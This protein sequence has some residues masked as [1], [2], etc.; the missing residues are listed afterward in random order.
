M[1]ECRIGPWADPER[2]A[3]LFVLISS[4]LSLH[5]LLVMFLDHVRI[6]AIAIPGQYA[7]FRLFIVFILINVV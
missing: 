2:L 5:Y 3:G 6:Y 4:L 1:G 7:Q